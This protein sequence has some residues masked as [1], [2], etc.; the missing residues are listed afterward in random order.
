MKAVNHYLNFDGHAEEAF[1][2]YRSVFGGDF[3]EVNR[4]EEMPTEK[5][6]PSHLKKRILHISLP[7]DNGSVLMGSDVMEGFGE[8]LHKGNNHYISLHTESKEESD[9]LFAKLSAGG[10][11]EME[12]QQTFWG[13]Y[14]GSFKDKFGIQWMIN[15]DKNR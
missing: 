15:F 3:K 4:Y 14:F 12:L 8:P 10:K 5:P 9:E 1:V 11:V 2:F 6:L 7:L 13:A